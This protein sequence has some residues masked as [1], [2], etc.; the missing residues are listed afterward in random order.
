MTTLERRP[1]AAARPARRYRFERRQHNAP[2]QLAQPAP[3]LDS[4]VP[5]RSALRTASLPPARAAPGMPSAPRVGRDLCHPSPQDDEIAEAISSSKAMGSSRLC[6]HAVLRTGRRMG[7]GAEPADSPAF[8]QFLSGLPAFER[9]P[10]ATLTSVLGPPGRKIGVLV[11]GR[12][13]SLH[14]HRRLRAGR[15]RSSTNDQAPRDLP[16]R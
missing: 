11:M 13:R 15:E 12:L 5:S 6:P 16:S 2:S 4:H 10:T 9:V 8:P 1:R 14:I 3:C 7:P